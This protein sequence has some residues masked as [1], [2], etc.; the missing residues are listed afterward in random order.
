MPTVAFVTYCHPP[1]LLRLHVPG[2]LEEIIASHKYPFD[3][4]VVVHQNCRGLEYS[5]V[6]DPS[7]RV[8]ESEDY[9]PGILAEFGIPEED[10]IAEELSGGE[11][12]PRHWKWQTIN[13]LIGLKEAT[14][15]YVVFSDCDCL[16]IKSSPKRSWVEEG[17]GILRKYPKVLIVSPSDGGSIR[18]DVIPEAFLTRNASQQL[19]IAERERFS[20]ID[21][22]VPWDGKKKAPGDPFEAFYVLMEGRIWRYL[23]KYKL[24]RA[25]LPNTWR[26]WHYDGGAWAPRNWIG[27]GR[28]VYSGTNDGWVLIKERR[29]G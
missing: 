4:I 13:H 23:D 1:H 15:D 12:Q 22:N 19:F 8:L 21:F 29:D 20:K 11:D 5:P 26:Y 28:P 7:V 9:H 10:A 14:S 25:F 24:W 18:E 16:L 2:V 17:I 27:E 3:E 6:K